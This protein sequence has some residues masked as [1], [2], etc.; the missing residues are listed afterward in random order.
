MTMKKIVKWTGIILVILIALMVVLPIIFKDK[1]VSMVKTQANNSLN[2]KVDFGD[3]ELSLFRSFPNFSLRIDQLSIINQAPFPGDTLVY[4]KQVDI[5]VDLFSVISGDQISI[6]SV[7]IQSPVMNFLVDRDG[8]ANWDIVKPG[9]PESPQSSSSSFKLKLKKYA[10]REGRILYDDRTLDYTLKLDNVNHDGSGDFTQDLFVLATHTRADKMYMSYDGMPLFSGVKTTADADIDM[11][12]KNFRFTFR[13]N[14]VTLN[15]LEIGV[16]GWLAMPDTSIDMDLKFSTPQSEFRNFL[17]LLPVIYKDGFSN[18]K[19]SGKLALSGYIKG[20]YNGASSPGFG[21]SVNIENGMFQYPSLPSS[22][23]NVQ[24]NLDI[25]N[26]DGIPDHT[27]INLSKL[28]LELAG[29]PFDAR[30]ILKTPVSD[31]D[32]DAFVKGKIDLGNMQKIVPLDK[33]TRLTGSITSDLSAR[34]RMSAVEKKQFDRFQAQGSLSV[35]GLVYGSP[36]MKQDF[37]LNTM[38]MTFNPSNVSLNAFRARSGKSDFD[39]SGNL[40][41]FIQYALKGQTLRGTLRLKSDVIDLNEFMTS[42]IQAGATPDTGSMK[43]LE[44]P[45]NLDFSMTASVGTLIYGDINIFNVN[46]TVEIRDQSIRMKDVAMRMLDGSLNMNGGYSSKNS[47]SPAFDFI[48]KLKDF[49]IRKTSQAFS[50]VQKLAPVAKY[51]SGRFSSDLAVQGKLDGKMNPDLNSVSGNGKL[52][53]GNVTVENLPAFSK[54]ADLLK[55][56]SW[57]RFDIPSMNPSFKIMNGRVYVDPFEVKINGFKS[58]VAGSNGLDQ[59]VD[60]TM[61]VDIPRSSFGGA[62]NSV[63]NNLVAGANSKGANLSVGDVVPVR[64]KIGGTVTDPKVSTDLNQQGAR[65]FE[66]IKAQGEEEFNR[67]KAA[68]EAKAREEADKLKSETE[69]RLN[70]EKSRAAAEADRIKKEAEARAKA[71]AD[72]AKKAAEQKAKDALKNM[73][74]FKK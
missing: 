51:C 44:I 72:S 10:V 55:M 24:V 2:A 57:K 56:P 29:D 27:L 6:R 20:R 13:N 43:V 12:M 71:Q 37:Q 31:P 49:D 53:T 25:H 63:L 33:G 3:F 52:M 4:A 32:F 47:K 68:A 48:L 67:Q 30:L 60:Y 11:D 66:S 61:A 7:S 23:N 73:N 22:V 5:S 16:D 26:P 46:G 50:S 17:S 38:Q 15:A 54:V 35:A 36:D 14:K 28:H 8:M 34:G 18:L 70:E 62:A 64:I 41:N 40:E 39:A 74:P 1:I 69:K 58:T 19:S 42:E 21:L 65:A 59:T 9:K 45:G